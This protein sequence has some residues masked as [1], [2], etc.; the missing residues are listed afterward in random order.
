MPSD[1]RV[2]DDSDGSKSLAADSHHT[3]GPHEPDA[4]S[5]GTATGS[6]PRRWRLLVRALKV[7]VAVVVSWLVLAYLILPALWR[8]YEHQPALESAP[9]TTVTAQGN[10]AIP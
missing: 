1:S 2:K 10:P 9:K 7:L 3:D 8:H 5:R 6:A 4:G